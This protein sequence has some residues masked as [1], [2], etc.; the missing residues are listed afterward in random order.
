MMTPDDFGVIVRSITPVMRDLLV[1]SLKGFTARLAALEQRAAVPG[2]PGIPGERGER[3]EIGPAGERGE[4]GE[5]GEPGI[6]ERGERGEKGLDGEI[7]PRGPEG[8][9]GRDGRDGMPGPPGE[10]GASGFDGMHG[11]DGR[12]GTLDNLK[13]VRESERVIAFC[14]KDGTPIEGGRIVLNHP[15][16]KDIFADGKTYDSNDLVQRNGGVWI[17]LRDNPPMRPG[18][19][20]SAVTG[21]QL[22]AQR[23][24]EGK[25]GLKGESGPQGPRGETGPIRNR[26]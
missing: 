4:R 22:F 23:G 19:A 20:D 18:E 24:R 1:T 13:M 17:A 5:T 25:Q 14:F 10:K 7:G 16:W 12:D 3:G 21:W 8:Q 6:G 2:P 15:I 26:Y 11:K 9:A